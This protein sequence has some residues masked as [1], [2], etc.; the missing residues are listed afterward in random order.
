[1]ACVLLHRQIVRVWLDVDHGSAGGVRCCR[2]PNFDPRRAQNLPRLR[3]IVE[4]EIQV[5]FSGIAAEEVFFRTR[6]RLSRS[7]VDVEGITSLAKRITTSDAEA[8][9]LGARVYR[10]SKSLIFV[11]RRMVRKVAMALMKS[12][13]LTA[14]DVR[15]LCGARASVS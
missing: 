4:R 7:L 6:A 11:H 14:A 12:R 8:V 1:V 9:A 5:Y 13:K 3:R 10:R 2:H 15:S